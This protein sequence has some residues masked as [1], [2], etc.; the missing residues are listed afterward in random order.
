M[1]A[2]NRLPLMVRVAL[3]PTSIIALLIIAAILGR[4]VIAPEADQ[5]AP[6]IPVQA[7]FEQVE[8]MSPVLNEWLF[9][10]QSRLQLVAQFSLT[11]DA[12]LK[13]QYQSLASAAAKLLANPANSGFQNLSQL[14]EV[15]E[16]LDAR[17]L[18][19][20]LPN[21][22][23]RAAETKQLHN[24]LMPEML[25][26]ALQ[27]KI[28][29][30]DRFTGDAAEKS[31][32]LLSHLQFAMSTL[33]GYTSDAKTSQRDA[34]LVELYAAENALNDLVASTNLQAYETRLNRLVELMPEFRQAATRILYASDELQK[35]SITAIELPKPEWFSQQQ[36]SEREVLAKQ[37]DVIKSD[38]EAFNA[39][40]LAVETNPPVEGLAGLLIGLLV[41]G[42]IV[43]L[44]LST[45]LTI[46]IKQSIASASQG[47]SEN[48]APEFKPVVQIINQY[49]DLLEATRSEIDQSVKQINHVSNELD[50]QVSQSG[51]SIDAQRQAVNG[52]TA[53]TC[54]LSTI[55]DQIKTQTTELDGSASRIDNE[56]TDGEQQLQKAIKQL[57]ELATQVAESVVTMDMLTEDRRRVSDV[58]SV[59]TSISEQTN[60]LALNAAIEAARAGEHGRGF[61]VVADEVRQLATQTQGSTEEI[62]HIMESLEEQAGK[63]ETMM[64]VSNEMS[65]Q[66]L[67]E[68]E[69]LAESFKHTHAIVE[70]VSALIQSVKNAASQQDES[71]AEI[72]EHVARLDKLLV[73]NQNLLSATTDQTRILE[74]LSAGFDQRLKRLAESAKTG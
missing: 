15:D 19:T 47:L 57:R 70:Q 31:Q 62:R 55:F 69:L 66:S 28:D 6:T 25:Q 50:A 20:L 32:A 16:E 7:E 38:I 13:N 40:T 26:L 37:L 14:K 36:A 43:T 8:A 45:L 42:I 9:N 21:Y 34:F 33:N 67:I 64:A 10:W 65:Q 74:S 46:S 24:E 51:Q 23:A 2:F 41:I 59:I 61:A 53:A 72:V 30:K 44:V 11:A 3:L 58:L 63:V 48:V 52:A 35:L 5:Q 27:L 17:F 49:L 39:A 54:D 12:G 71:C 22:A 73:E 56:S 29:L 1:N 60:L 68:I 18:Q 4:S